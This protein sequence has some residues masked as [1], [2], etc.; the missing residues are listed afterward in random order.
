MQDLPDVLDQALRVYAMLGALL[1]AL[2][3]TE[4]ERVLQLFRVTQYWMGRA[5]VQVF[6]CPNTSYILEVLPTPLGA[7][8]I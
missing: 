7:E 6:P 3:E 8:E 4:W 2:V 1:V 5:L